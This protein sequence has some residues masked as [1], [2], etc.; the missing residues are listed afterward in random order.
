MGQSDSKNRRSATSKAR[1]WVG[2][3]GRKADFFTPLLTKFVSSFGRNDVSSF[4]VNLR[5]CER[6][7]AKAMATLFVLDWQWFVEEPCRA[8][9]GAS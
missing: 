1:L 5:L 3:A 2:K 6:E 9:D 7:R 4:V 8:A